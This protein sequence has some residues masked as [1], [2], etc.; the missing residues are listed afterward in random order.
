MVQETHTIQDP[1]TR[2]AR[3]KLP[4]TEFL[5]S[6][7]LSRGYL[8]E[9]DQ[10]IEQSENT[11]GHLEKI[12]KKNRRRF[13]DR[14]LFA[15][16]PEAKD[17]ILELIT[18]MLVERKSVV[19]RIKVALRNATTEDQR[20]RVRLEGERKLKEVDGHLNRLRR[21]WRF[22]KYEKPDKTGSDRI[23]QAA[24][25]QAKEVP[26]QDFLDVEFKQVGNKLLAS[27]PLHNERTP[28][29]Y[30]YQDTNTAWCYG[31]QQ[32]GD[33]I[34]IAKLTHGYSFQEAVAFLI[35]K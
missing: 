33:S 31:C 4:E 7:R 20:S 21:Q 27:C 32:G 19:A 12:R 5:W 29:F 22:I 35:N 17:M 1:R 18:T 16:F 11:V 9:T 24:I 25:E 3:R 10:E 26:I 14:E 13:T 28:S 23:D 8:Y 34:T 30:V 15:L 6:W 2:S